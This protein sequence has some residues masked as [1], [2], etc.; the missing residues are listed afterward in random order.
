MVQYDSK[1]TLTICYYFS[2]KESEGSR[3]ISRPLGMI[4]YCTVDLGLVCQKKK[5]SNIL[6]PIIPSPT[7][8]ISSKKIQGLLYST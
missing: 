7:N 3:K 5:I 6:T 4:R 2:I 8:G 1:I